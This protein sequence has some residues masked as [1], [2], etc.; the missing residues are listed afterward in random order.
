MSTK[1]YKCKYEVKSNDR[2][3]QEVKYDRIIDFIR[4]LY[5]VIRQKLILHI[6]C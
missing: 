2:L 4:I 5:M 1:K 6:K 3:K